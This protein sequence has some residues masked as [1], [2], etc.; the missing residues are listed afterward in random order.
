[1]DDFQ[2]L[3]LGL[4]LLGLVIAL[5]GGVP[6]IINIRN[7]WRRSAFDVRFDERNSLACFVESPVRDRDGKLAILL[8]RVTVVGKGSGP[9]F[10]A[11]VTLQVRC[12]G[13]W[14]RGKLFQPIRFPETDKNGITKDAVRI[15]LGNSSE[16]DQMLIASWEDF[17]PGEVAL[18]FGEPMTFSV[19]STFHVE[20]ADYSSCDL[21]RIDLVDFLGKR[22][23][24]RIDKFEF[25]TRYESFTLTEL[26]VGG[27]ES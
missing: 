9:S 10:L 22:Y 19:A 13:E 6:G 16:S 8:Y 7:E 17:R 25:E 15:R 11:D 2:P 21:L 5:F 24:K 27:S 1:M 20:P 26:D 18:D 4:A 12:G 14:V 3:T 23:R